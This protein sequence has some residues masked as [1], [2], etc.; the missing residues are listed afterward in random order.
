ME[1]PVS[2]TRS[3]FYSF[4]R[5]SSYPFVNDGHFTRW[6]RKRRVPWRRLRYGMPCGTLRNV[7]GSHAG[8]TWLPWLRIGQALHELFVI[9]I[10]VITSPVVI[11]RVVNENV[12]F[13]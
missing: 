10:P 6:L 5:T 13:D 4:R 3:A 11:D 1:K 7:K 12:E 9:Q 8:L 2:T